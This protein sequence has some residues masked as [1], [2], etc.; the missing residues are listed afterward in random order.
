MQSLPKSWQIW[1]V[2]WRTCMRRWR[3]CSRSSRSTSPPRMPSR[4]GATAHYLVLEHARSPEGTLA[5][6]SRNVYELSGPKHRNR[7]WHDLHEISLV[8]KGQLVLKYL[9]SSENLSSLQGQ[10]ARCS[11]GSVYNMLPSWLPSWLLHS[12]PCDSHTGCC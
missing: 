8:M 9:T 5:L 2:C 3:S 10:P 1:R 4:C 6:K 11:E 7:P 12:R